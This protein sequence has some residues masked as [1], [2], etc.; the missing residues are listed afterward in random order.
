VK[1]TGSAEGVTDGA[2]VGSAACVEPGAV[3][4][5]GDGS[6]VVKTHD[7][8]RPADIA[9]LSRFIREMIAYAEARGVRVVEPEVVQRTRIRESM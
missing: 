5:K 9:R 2:V 6:G 7:A 8:R 4:D 3:V 1:A